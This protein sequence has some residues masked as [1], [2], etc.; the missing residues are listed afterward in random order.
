MRN[1]RDSYSWIRGMTKPSA[2]LRSPSGPGSVAA[3]FQEGNGM[4]S[5]TWAGLAAFAVLVT[6]AG[7]SP[8]RAQDA[9]TGTTTRG[10]Q[11]RGGQA[12][13]QAPPV[14]RRLPADSVTQH[15]LELPGRTLK[16]TATAGTIPLRNNEGR[17]LAEFAYIAYTVPGIEAAKRPV[18]FAFNGG[19]GSASAWLHLGGLGPW[20]LPLDA[21]EPSA[22]APP[23]VV[24]NAET[25]LDF[26]D[27][28]FID[29]IGT[30]YSRIVPPPQQQPGATGQS[31]PQ[32]GGRDAGSRE[33]GGTRYFW[34]VTGDVDSTAEFIQLWLK[35]T[36]RFASP[37]VI[38]GESYG[39]IRG[40]KVTSALQTRYGVGVN[41]LVLVSPVLE[42]GVRGSW[43]SASPTGLVSLLPSLAASAMEQR[44]KTV[45]LDR[46]MLTA[47][48][49]YARNEYLPDLMR[50]PN[51]KAA[52]DRMTA[53]VAALT[54][55][56]E[57]TVKQY[58]ARIDSFIYRREANRANGRTASV[59]DSSVR[60]YDPDPTTYF[61]TS[62]VDPFTSGYAAPMT[63]AMGELYAE[64]LKYKVDATYNMS[65]SSANREWVY[66]NQPFAMDSSGDLRAALAL[67]PKLRVLVTHGFNDTI[68]PYFASDM[69]LAQIPA[70]GDTTRLNLIVYPG[71][72]MF[73]SREASRKAFREDVRKLVE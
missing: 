24:P 16:F 37:K 70:F 55:L 22:S 69:V 2:A 13:T 47:A 43:R 49:T 42:Y 20:R 15:T 72:H 44:D 7:A 64:R 29:P 40:P 62:Q 9:E 5:T 6:V 41:A 18:T 25:F 45:V 23:V 26:T 39:G 19:P 36:S 59:Y 51:D 3:Q 4:R 54:G 67:D 28:V 50:G 34:S 46:A 71:G 30:G 56:P 53:R 27:L 10:N 31:P 60:S 21:P 14:E 35:K 11:Q 48:E 63:S 68:T 73:Y 33:S 17:L 58:G 1:P 57:A 38:L 65:N 12:A 32:G 66:P 61:P 52:V 8:I